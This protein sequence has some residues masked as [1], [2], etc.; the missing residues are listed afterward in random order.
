MARSFT[1]K[2]KIYLKLRDC[3]GRGKSVFSW[4]RIKLKIGKN[5]KIRLEVA[6]VSG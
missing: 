4:I 1:G 2:R 6:E 5:N 3:R